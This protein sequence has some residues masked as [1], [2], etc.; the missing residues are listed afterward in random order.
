MNTASKKPETLNLLALWQL[1]L[2]QF[3]LYLQHGST[4]TCLGHHKLLTRRWSR[5]REVD[6]QLA[7]MLL[8]QS[9]RID[10]RYNKV[11]E[12]VYHNLEPIWRSSNA[13]ILKLST[14]LNY[15]GIQLNPAF[16]KLCCDHPR[17]FNKVAIYK[18]QL[19]T[20][21]C[22][23]QPRHAQCSE[24]SLHLTSMLCLR[25]NSGDSVDMLSFCSLIPKQSLC[26]AIWLSLWSEI[27]CRFKPKTRPGSFHVLSLRWILSWILPSDASTSCVL[28][29]CMP[30]TANAS[31]R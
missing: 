8:I 14:F 15:E 12:V 29:K 19:G 6:Q 2:I 30:I 20:L 24:P 5:L 16:N 1:S 11:S 10:V 31:P 26:D 23:A 4:A 25:L 9:G 28:Y 22:L 27:K 3:L 18:T 7:T 21:E 17:R 13:R